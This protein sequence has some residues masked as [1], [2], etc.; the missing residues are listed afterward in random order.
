MTA[1]D[2]TTVIHMHD[3]PSGWQRNPRYVY[4]G[5]PGK[6]MAGEYGNPHPVGYCDVCKKQHARGEAL[7]A[8]AAE[9]VP[10]YASDP[11]YRVKVDWLRGKVLVCF[12]APAK[13]C[14]GEVYVNLI[15]GVPVPGLAP[16][17]PP[18][19]PAKKS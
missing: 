19:G 14:H 9:A 12:C 16:V 18:V 7:A 2:V 11:A 17:A 10:R 3:A 15:H 5:R 1:T 4:I 6:G 13:R 8:F